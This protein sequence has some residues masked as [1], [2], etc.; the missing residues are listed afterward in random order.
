[1]V[2]RA[3]PNL[4]LNVFDVVIRWYSRFRDTFAIRRAGSCQHNEGAFE[5]REVRSKTDR[6]RITVPDDICPR[7]SICPTTQ[8]REARLL[9]FFFAGSIQGGKEIVTWDILA[10]QGLCSGLYK[11]LFYPHWTKGDVIWLYDY[12]NF[13]WMKFA[14]L[15]TNEAKEKGECFCPQ[16]TAPL[17]SWCRRR[18]EAEE[19][20][21]SATPQSTLEPEKN[22]RDALVWRRA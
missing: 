9:F 21:V 16:M 11:L 22:M 10:S 2:G 18:W 15:Q 20:S 7:I 4:S 3:K 17:T 14:F 1:M 6:G 8:W 5:L 12:H 19:R 13:L